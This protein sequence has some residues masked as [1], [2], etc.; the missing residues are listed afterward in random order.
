MRHKERAKG[1]TSVVR[2]WK[3]CDETGDRM[4]TNGQ[5]ARVRA[6]LAAWQGRWRWVCEC[7]R[8]KEREKANKYG[9]RGEW[10][11][12]GKALVMVVSAKRMCVCV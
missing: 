5:P 4:R 9:V 1:N 12:V 6:S 11:R 8:E 7:E 10:G 2:V 3:R